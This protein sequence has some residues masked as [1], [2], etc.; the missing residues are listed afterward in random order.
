MRGHPYSALFT[1]RVL[2]LLNERTQN[3]CLLDC[4]SCNYKGSAFRAHGLRAVRTHVLPS[5]VGG[6]TPTARAAAA[7]CEGRRRSG[8]PSLYGGLH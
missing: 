6:S 5:M 3:Q 7:P 8:N 4:N 1:L 2:K